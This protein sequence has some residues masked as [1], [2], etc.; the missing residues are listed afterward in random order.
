MKEKI[1]DSLTPEQEAMIPVYF[2]KWK[3]IGMEYKEIDR[4]KARGL[5]LK[6][7]ELIKIKPRHFIFCDS[8]LTCELMINF[9]KN[10]DSSSLYSSLYS[11]L[12]S[13]LYSSLYISRKKAQN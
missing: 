13:S 6:Y 5:L 8:P 12:R 4:E 2:E 1:I 9:L 10:L 7:L 11:S 3:K